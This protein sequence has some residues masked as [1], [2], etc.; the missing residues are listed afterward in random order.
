MPILFFVCVCK[1]YN[2]VWSKECLDLKF[3][4]LVNLPL[5]TIFYKEQFCV[6][7]TIS[8]CD[9]IVALHIIILFKGQWT[10]HIIVCLSSL[11][12]QTTNCLVTV[13]ACAQL[14]FYILTW[15]ISHKAKTRRAPFPLTFQKWILKLWS[16]I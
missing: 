9:V 2:F 4:W 12:M 8:Q 6:F 3:D 5:N 10:V 1:F 16:R 14:I 15:P 13:L 11:C 7:C